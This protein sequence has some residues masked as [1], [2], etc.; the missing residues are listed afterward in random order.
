MAT[1][2]HSEN[3]SETTMKSVSRVLLTGAGVAAAFALA[4]APASAA[5]AAAPAPASVAAQACTW[6]VTSSVVKFGCSVSLPLIGSVSGSFS[7]TF[8]GDGTASGTVVF[9]SVV[10]SINGTWNGGPFVSGKKAT[11]N[12][13]ASTPIGPVSGSIVV[14]VP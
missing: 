13:S 6:Q 4:A 14:D 11:I 3:E 7:G 2:S 10:G 1:S 5:V 8:H 12:Y 9:K